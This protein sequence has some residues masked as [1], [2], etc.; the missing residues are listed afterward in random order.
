M[1]SPSVRE[2][3]Q[4]ARPVAELRA[5]RTDWYRI[6]NLV[7]SA[8]ARVYIYD[9]IGYWGVTAQDFARD[10][11]ALDVDSIEL[12]INS[13]GG[14]VFDGIAIY[15]V[16]RQHKAKVTTY[17]DSLAASAASFIAMAGDEVIMAPNATMMIHDGIGLAIG[18]AA[19]MR[20]TAELLDRVS[21]NIASI[22]A[23]RAGGDVESWRT[24]M[25]A[26]TWYSASEAVAAGL[27]Q[28]VGRET[29]DTTSNRWDLSIFNYAGRS[30]A[31]APVVNDVPKAGS[32]PAPASL[33]QPAPDPIT[34]PAL[35]IPSDF[36]DLIRTAFTREA[37]AP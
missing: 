8:S 22:Y 14:E 35:T 24:A 3:F 1:G 33:T 23:E 27:A 9:E 13:P 30:S 6:T 20:E 18:N 32:E 31:P 10:I 36:A 28:R 21:D 12:H 29:E 34:V 4:V 17:V 15:E 11:V 16:L 37:V 2:R 5:G 25:R 7:E 19:T 26:E